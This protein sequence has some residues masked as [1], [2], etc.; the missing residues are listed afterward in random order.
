MAHVKSKYKIF[1]RF[2]HVQAVIE[3]LV[4]WVVQE[5]YRIIDCNKGISRQSADIIF[6]V[7]SFGFHS[8]IAPW[9]ELIV[10]II[11][12]IA[13]RL[14]LQL[15]SSTLLVWRVV[16]TWSELYALCGAILSC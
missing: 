7:I 12:P 16:R 14:L 10:F 6:I 4:D 11:V 5:L 13:K 1:F 8:L 2:L 3:R 15:V 9:L